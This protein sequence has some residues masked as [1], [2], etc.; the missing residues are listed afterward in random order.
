M[1]MRSALNLNGSNLKSFK[2]LVFIL[3][4]VDCVYSMIIWFESHMGRKRDNHHRKS[5]SHFV[6][7]SYRY[8]KGLYM[9][10]VEY[11]IEYLQSKLSRT[12]REKNKSLQKTFDVALIG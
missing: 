8:F 3:H 2:M 7:D 11:A 4:K 10:E 5:A 9:G 1:K 6:N 12:V